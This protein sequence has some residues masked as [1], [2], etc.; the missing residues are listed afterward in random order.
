MD[1]TNKY[2]VVYSST[3]TVSA[4]VMGIETTTA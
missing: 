4:V 1:S 2:L 3:A